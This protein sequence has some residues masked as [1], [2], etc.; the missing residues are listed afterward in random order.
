[1]AKRILFLIGSPKLESE[2]ASA[3]IEKRFA[4]FLYKKSFEIKKINVVRSAKT[5]EDKKILL[6]M[7]NNNDVLIFIS[8]VYLDTVPSPVIETMQFLNNKKHLINGPKKMLG[9]SVCGYPE[10]FHNDTALRVYKCFAGHMGF[11]WV[12]GLGIAKGP[13]YVYARQILSMLG[14]YRNLEKS[15]SLIVQALKDEETIPEE[16]VEIMK[17]SI[18]PD[19]LYTSIAILSAKMLAIKDGVWN[20]YKRS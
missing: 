16:A 2:S 4:K 18:I 13:A 8:P 14:V 3:V 1:M 19:W 10:A 15:I 9:I 6:T 17:R 11:V 20:L 12:G 7:I 5:E